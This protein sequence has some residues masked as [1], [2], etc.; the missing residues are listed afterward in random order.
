MAFR[1]RALPPK[2][3][4][5]AN[6]VQGESS[7]PPNDTLTLA[8]C[9]TTLTVMYDG[10][11][12]E[13]V[14]SQR[15]QCR[16]SLPSC[17]PR[18]FSGASSARSIRL[19]QPGSELPISAAWRYW[20]LPSRIHRGSAVSCS[21]SYPHRARSCGYA[22]SNWAAATYPLHAERQPPVPSLRLRGLVHPRLKS[23]LSAYRVPCPPKS[24]A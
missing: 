14:S 12:W 9:R 20:R 8:P 2:A 10:D 17:P 19:G 21:P 1:H 15:S 3:M 7:V 11:R 16:R 24:D 4:R 6:Q 13:P 18:L 23:R 22:R 5:Q